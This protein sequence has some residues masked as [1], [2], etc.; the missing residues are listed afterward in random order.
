MVSLA[1][2]KV[3]KPNSEAGKTVK[4]A[5]LSKTKVDIERSLLRMGFSFCN[6]AIAFKPRVA[7]RSQAQKVAHHVPAINSKALL[8]WGRSGKIRKGFEQ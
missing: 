3:R 1:P 5:A 7:A 2:Y 8:F 6:S 4:E